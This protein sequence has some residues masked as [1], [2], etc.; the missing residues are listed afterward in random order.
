[1]GDPSEANTVL[2]VNY[3]WIDKSIKINFHVPG[4]IEINKAWAIH[5]H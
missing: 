2:V 5:R 3:D 4:H 1:M